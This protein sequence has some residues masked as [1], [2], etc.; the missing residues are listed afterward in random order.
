MKELLLSGAWSWA[1]QYTGTWK[2]GSGTTVPSG[3]TSC[4][5]W[6]GTANGTTYYALVYQT[7]VQATVSGSVVTWS[8]Y[9]ETFQ[10]TLSPTVSATV[11][12]GT[13]TLSAYTSS[14]AVTW[15]GHFVGTPSTNWIGVSS[16]NVDGVINGAQLAASI[17]V[18]APDTWSSG[19]SFTGYMHPTSPQ[20]CH[21]VVVGGALLGFVA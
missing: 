2:P 15:S 14:T 10:A 18:N 9:G 4:P 7:V 17:L 8:A 16:G 3:V 6:L 13:L 1:S 5:V 20:T 11:G 19:A 12:S 21:V